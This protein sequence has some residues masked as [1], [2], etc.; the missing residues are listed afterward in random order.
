MEGLAAILVFIVPED[1]LVG[2]RLTPYS[3]LE[4]VR[5][6]LRITSGIGRQIGMASGGTCA[7]K[8]AFSIGPEA[9]CENAPIGLADSIVTSKQTA[10]L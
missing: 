9:P 3:P 6:R 7:F 4:R 1:N 8:V 10:S 5:Y 2:T